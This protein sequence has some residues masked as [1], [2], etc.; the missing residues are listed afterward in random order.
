AEYFRGHDSLEVSG[1]MQ[2]VACESS[3]ALHNAI[4]HEGILGLRVWRTLG[5]VQRSGKRFWIVAA[6]AM[7]VSLAV[8]SM[9]VQVDHYIIATGSVAPTLRRQVF[10]AHEGVV[11]SLYVVDGQAVDEGTPLIQL[12]NAEL[13]RNG[14]SIAGQIQTMLQRMSSIKAVR[15]SGESKQ[16]PSTRMAVEQ[17]QLES[18]LANLRAQYAIIE[19]QQQDLLIRSPLKGT[20]VGWQLEK[21]LTQR[22]VSRGDLL[23]GVVDESGPW[24]LKLQIPDRD[25][26]ALLRSVKQN[27]RLPV[28]FAVATQP[29]RSYD[30]RLKDVATAARIDERKQAVI[31]TTARVVLRPRSPSTSDVFDPQDVRI[32]AD[33]IA[34][35]YCGQRSVL[36]SWFSDV[37]DFVNRNVL[38]YFR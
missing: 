28:T 22:P 33:V 16:T 37:F 35:V 29:E 2:A 15:L 27:E 11:K 20:V 8:A 19:A 10:A 13:Q 25:A 24:E 36:K 18:E 9:V 17:Q 14:D 21:R 23:L 30:A 4:E 1:V 26:G 6:I 3:V 7:F 5:R 32:G 38:F 12:E 31:D 34:R